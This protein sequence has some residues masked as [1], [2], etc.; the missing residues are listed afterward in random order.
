MVILRSF[1]KKEYHKYGI[2]IE[3]RVT[4]KRDKENIQ[5]YY[6]SIWV[7]SFQNSCQ[8]SANFQTP[9][10]VLSTLLG[11]EIY[12]VQNFQELLQG[13]QNCSLALYHQ[14]QATTTC[15]W[16]ILDHI[17]LKAEPQIW[18]MARVSTCPALFGRTLVYMTFQGHPIDGMLVESSL[19]GL[20]LF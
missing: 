15:P 3:D 17:H 2:K 16:F 4:S 5:V 10:S 13:A 20:K 19:K 6:S 9:I 7:I 11:Q 8:F 14:R 1:F 18:F 12:L